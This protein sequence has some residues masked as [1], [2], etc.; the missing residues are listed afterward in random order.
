LFGSLE[1]RAGGETYFNKSDLTKSISI[2]AIVC[3][4]E[5]FAA[6]SGTQMALNPLTDRRQIRVTS[7]DESVSETINAHPEWMVTFTDNTAGNG[8]GLDIYNT[9]STSDQAMNNRIDMFV[10]VPYPS[11]SAE[12][13]LI[14]A[15]APDLDIHEVR[16]LAKFSQECHKAF[17]SRDITCGFS[18]RNLRAILGMIS[19][20]LTVKEAIGLNFINRVAKS[21]QSDVNTLVRSIWGE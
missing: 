21:E 2:P 16:R 17:E 1:M 19:Q 20:H 12:R 4:D 9:R 15:L 13:R 14:T 3:C 7:H 11:E 5:I 10:H 18:V 8:D 6:T